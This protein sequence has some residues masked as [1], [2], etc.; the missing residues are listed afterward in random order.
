LECRGGRCAA[1]DEERRMEYA[2]KLHAHSH[3]DWDLP[4]IEE[5]RVRV[6]DRHDLFIGFGP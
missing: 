1:D 6:N 5:L 3:Q 2:A 4:A